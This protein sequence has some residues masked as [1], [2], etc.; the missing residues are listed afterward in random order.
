[1]GS[2]LP[3]FYIMMG[4][5]REKTHFFDLKK[6]PAESG[7]KL[8]L[9]AYPELAEGAELGDIA[10]A[11]VAGYLCHLAT[12]EV[13]IIDI[14]RPLFGPAS[15]LGDEPMANLL[16]RTLQYEL[17]IRSRQD[18]DYMSQVRALL[19][20]L[21]L[22]EDIG[23]IDAS[24]VRQ[25]HER[26]RNA[27]GRVPTWDDFPGFVERFLVPFKKVESE[28]LDGFLASLP[29]KREWVLSYVG[30]E[31]IEAFREKAITRSVTAV[32]EYLN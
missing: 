3:D 30:W 28:S 8:F 6:E 5:T 20:R 16:D 2:T 25:W 23:P 27:S 7:I 19:G 26:V 21:S 24:V 15:P 29:D 11:L 31:R 17:D 13:W 14:Y 12:D 18:E 1:L 4:Q 9:K 32:Q 10:K 22:S